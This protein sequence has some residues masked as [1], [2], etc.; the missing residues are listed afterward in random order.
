MC[1]G[2]IYI[3]GFYFMLIKGLVI[4]EEGWIVCWGNL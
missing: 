1:V 3:L 4:E 2:G